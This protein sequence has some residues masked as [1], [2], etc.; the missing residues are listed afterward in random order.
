MLQQECVAMKKT[1]VT[2]AVMLS[3]MTAANATDQIDAI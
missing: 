1:L 3:M 2:T